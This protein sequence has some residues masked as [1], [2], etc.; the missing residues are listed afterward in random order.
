MRTT[1]KKL[2]VALTV[3]MAVGSICFA[4][5]E[6]PANKEPV[7]ITADTMTYN[8]KT[9]IAT[10]DGNVVMT[11]GTAE[12][13]GKHVE[14]NS[15]TKDGLVTGGVIAKKDDATLT[16]SQ[17]QIVK[18]EQVIA[19]GNV[20]AIRQGYQFNSER[21]EFFVKEERIFAPVASVITTKDGTLHSGQLEYFLKTKLGKAYKGV[22]IFS[23]A[24]QITATS[25]TATYQGGENATVLLSG[26]AHAV[27]NGNTLDGDELRYYMAENSF[28]ADGKTKVVYY[29]A[30]KDETTDKKN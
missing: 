23:P 27:Q 12:I 13:T 16:C 11:Q 15:Q 21:L 17:V 30:E 4:A 28:V 14:Y 19:T 26:N 18:Q 5:A 9:N 10:A 3:V 6:Q 20:V 1:N 22:K 24:R 7:E 8:T 25:E 2:L 29:P